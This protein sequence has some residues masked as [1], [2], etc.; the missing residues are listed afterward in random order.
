MNFLLHLAFTVPLMVVALLARRM[1]GNWRSP[2]ALFA[3][4]WW[5]LFSIPALLA[6]EEYISPGA[7]CF[8]VLA[9]LSVLFGSLLA[10]ALADRYRIETGKNTLHIPE[11]RLRSA[12]VISIIIG[13]WFT[14]TVLW[15]EGF[16]LGQLFQMDQLAQIVLHFAVGRYQ[17]TYQDPL[18]SRPMLVFVYLAPLLG[19]LYLAC[20]KRGNWRK[21]V[22]GVISISPALCI[23]L[24]RS[25]KWPLVI[26]LAEYIS[27]RI[28]MRISRGIRFQLKFQ[29]IFGV[30]LGAIV[31]AAIF[32]GSLY[33]RL[34]KNAQENGFSIVIGKI[35]GYLFAYVTAFSRWFDGHWRQYLLDFGSLGLGSNSLPGLADV[36]GVKQRLVGLYGSE[37]DV[38][39][40]AGGDQSNI[41]SFFRLLIQDY[42]IPGAL[43]ALFIVGLVM[44]IV[45]LKINSRQGLW[46]YTVFIACLLL[47]FNHLII[48]SNTVMFAFFLYAGVLFFLKA[49]KSQEADLGP[50]AE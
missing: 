10:S 12:L 35:S 1:E 38:I 20:G 7:L 6:P 26:A 13:I 29:T 2:G 23:T 37:E 42:S 28:A 33:G 48:G 40:L 4:V 36:M 31:C 14:P 15:A 30:A 9:V 27:A 18:I 8:I 47:S 43:I 45:L 5:I 39:I 17:E 34:D 24:L 49:G 16:S 46:G 44:K 32:I 21:T 50:F 19:G 3:L 22:L 11:A 41:Y 25:E